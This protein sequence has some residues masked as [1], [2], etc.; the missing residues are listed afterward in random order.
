MRR[1]QF[2]NELGSTN[3]KTVTK[4]DVAEKLDF[5][6]RRFSDLQALIRRNAL[7]SEH[8]ERQQLVQEFFF[9]LIGAIELV[10]QFVN[11]RR[12]LGLDSENVSVRAIVDRLP[13]TDQLKSAL[14]SLY[15][16]TRRR[17]VPN[18]PY[19]DDGLL[20]RAYNYRHQ[21]THRYRNPFNFRLGASPSA[22]FSLDPR[23]SSNRSSIR[24]VEDDLQDMLDLVE[25]RCLAALQLC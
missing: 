23:D 17:P 12:A 4:D 15:V 1:P 6:R 21:V 11:E 14:S 16:Q 10:A 19:G 5:A 3:T 20:F 24:S 2:N 7:G 9:H 22:S 13:P 8:H 25:T 18:D